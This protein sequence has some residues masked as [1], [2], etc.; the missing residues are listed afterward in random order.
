MTSEARLKAIKEFLQEKIDRGLFS[1]V[2][3]VFGRGGE[4]PLEVQMGTTAF[5]SKMPVGPN[6]LFDIQSITKAV[7]T[8]PLALQLVRAGRISLTEL[9]APHL[10]RL[11]SGELPGSGLKDITFL[12][13][14]THTSG[15]SDAELERDFTSS[16]DLWSAM[17]RAAPRRF[18][19][20]SHM[21]SPKDDDADVQSRG[22]TANRGDARRSWGDR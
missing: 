2:S 20:R 7:A 11:S 16:A 8:A 13:L 19:S 14:L 4:K 1:G 12:Q 9:V 6:T 10:S 15:L 3:V 5:H 17:Y 21:E 22:C 18:A